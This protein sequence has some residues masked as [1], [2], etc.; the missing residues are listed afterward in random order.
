MIVTFF[1]NYLTYLLRVKYRNYDRRGDTW[2]LDAGVLFYHKNKNKWEHEEA[3]R[4]T[5]TWEFF[6]ELS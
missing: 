2:V 1:P 4:I 3:L 5:Q 6:N